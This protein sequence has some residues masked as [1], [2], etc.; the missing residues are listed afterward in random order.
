MT[1]LTFLAGIAIG[2]MVFANRAERWVGSSQARGQAMTAPDPSSWLLSEQETNSYVRT[3]NE[4]G[5]HNFHT[6]LDSGEVLQAQNLATV[7]GVAALIRAVSEHPGEYLNAQ[8]IRRMNR[9]HA[10]VVADLLEAAL[11]MRRPSQLLPD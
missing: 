5:T 11:E 10:D 4:P 9:G 6:A 3:W 8:Q 2:V 1:V 7:R